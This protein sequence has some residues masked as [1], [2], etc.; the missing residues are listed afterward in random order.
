MSAIE[1]SN[2]LLI[3]SGGGVNNGAGLSNTSTSKES[4]RLTSRST[5]SNDEDPSSSSIISSLRIELSD[6]LSQR[7]TLMSQNKELMQ[8]IEEQ[9]KRLGIFETEFENHTKHA[10]ETAVLL[11]SATQAAQLSDTANIHL[12]AQL[13]QQSALVK[14]AR[15]EADERAL[16]NQELKN[17]L[18]TIEARL[19]SEIAQITEALRMRKEAHYTALERAST[20]E[21]TR[22]QAIDDAHKLQVALQ[23]AHARLVEMEAR[24]V[25]D[26]RKISEVNE[27]V[28]MHAKESDGLREAVKVLQLRHS[29]TDAER[30]RLA[31]ELSAS[32]LQLRKGTNTLF[33]LLDRVK[34]AETAKSRAIDSL[35]SRETE[36]TDL[37]SQI[38]SIKRTNASLEL[39]AHV[40]SEEVEIYKAHVATLAAKIRDEAQRAAKDDVGKR[41]TQEQNR[42]L[43]ARAALLAGHLHAAEEGNIAERARSKRLE[44]EL[45]A[46]TSLCSDLRSKLD[47]NDRLEA[48]HRALEKSHEELFDK[49]S[50]LQKDLE[51]AVQKL[52]D[53]EE[54]LKATTT[55][56]NTTS[57][58]LNA[59]TNGSKNSSMDNNQE[60]SLENDDFDTLMNAP[61]VNTTISSMNESIGNNNN[62]NLTLSSSTS[63]SNQVIHQSIP[64]SSSLSPVFLPELRVGVGLLLIKSETKEGRR[65][66]MR[67][68]LNEQIKRA[69]MLKPQVVRSG[70]VKILCHLLTLLYSESDKRATLEEKLIKTINQAEGAINLNQYYTQCIANNDETKRRLIVKLARTVMEK[71]LT[72]AR[73]VNTK[74]HSHS[75]ESTSPSRTPTSSLS[76]D[77]ASIGDEGVAVLLSSLKNSIQSSSHHLVDSRHNNQHTHGED[78]DSNIDKSLMISIQELSLRNNSITDEG[79]IAIASFISKGFTGFFTTETAT[80]ATSLIQSNSSIEGKEKEIQKNVIN[81]QAEEET[82]QGTHSSSSSSSVTFVR[83]H[84]INLSGNHISHVG[85]KAL[86]EAAE[87]SSLVQHVFVHA[88]GRIEALGTRSVA[89]IHGANGVNGDKHG[90]TSTSTTTALSLIAPNIS[91]DSSSVMHV[92]KINNTATELITVESVIDCSDQLPITQLSP[93]PFIQYSSSTSSNLN[94][95]QIMSGSIISENGTMISSSILS[96]SGSTS[97]QLNTKHNKQMPSSSTSRPLTSST[98]PHLKHNPSSSLRQGVIKSNESVSSNRVMTS[99]SSSSSSSLSSNSFSNQQISSFNM[100]HSPV[101][102]ASTSLIVGEGERGGGGFGGS[103]SAALSQLIEDEEKESERE[104]MTS[105]MVLSSS[106]SNS[107]KKTNLQKQQQLSS[108]TTASASTASTASNRA[109]IEQQT[110][111]A[112]WMGRAGG[113]D[114]VPLTLQESVGPSVL[115]Q[116]G[117]VGG[118]GHGGHRS[119]PSSQNTHVKGHGT[120][121]TIKTSTT[122]STI[123]EEGGG[124][125]DGWITSENLSATI[126]IDASKAVLDLAGRVLFSIPSGSGSGSGSSAHI[127]S[128]N[129]KA[130]VNKGNV[131]TTKP[132]RATSAKTNSAT[133]RSFSSSS[134]SSS[135]EKTSENSNNATRRENDEDINRVSSSQDEEDGINNGTETSPLEAGNSISSWESK[136]S[137][138]ELIDTTQ[139]KSARGSGVAAA[140]SKQIH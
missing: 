83:I 93:H 124:E 114:V 84:S 14:E 38:E 43:A 46:A 50:E 27:S 96:K 132:I 3:S 26:Q 125:V 117:V 134:S 116:R 2:L 122:P 63:S 127:H 89:A 78:I 17:A 59:K 51:Y 22:R 99:P 98:V 88:S 107:T 58:S 76:L 29:S 112:L 121:T 18:G 113:L 118:G 68:N 119:I 42:V 28:K 10:E 55:A 120:N 137:E 91:I 34:L 56:S 77:D 60:E 90:S 36:V 92:H 11:K 74:S 20:A 82:R 24:H 135:F 94:N 133:G 139:V 53:Q 72:H 54:L 66:L 49:A 41:E 40:A 25:E 57:T 97:Q 79:A 69:Q 140:R 109:L 9:D 4:A 130:I 136:T 71:A 80:N 62:N 23:G 104:R 87:A 48:A 1:L 8:I 129:V 81:S 102:S 126:D 115:L 31:T 123:N 21:E 47:Q 33:A 86:A 131:T 64:S 138:N 111:E 103:G 6:V 37:L 32:L 12:S 30:I 52:K 100:I 39:K 19:G 5:T 65:L 45:T 61:L 44:M 128:T 106:S 13:S 67:L 101:T 75:I 110:K 16:Q 35:R 15:H 105:S 108:H 85:L 7:S 95:S 73:Y 70:F